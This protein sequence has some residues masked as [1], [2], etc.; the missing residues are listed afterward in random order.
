MHSEPT[1]ARWLRWMVSAGA[2][3]PLVIFQQYLSPFHFG[4]VILFRSLVEV[5]AVLFIMLVWREPDYRPK[6]NPITWTFLALAGV[7]TMTMLTGAAPL[8]SWWGTL[9][10][11]GG[12]FAFWH[13]FAF[14]LIAVSVLR[15]RE[16]WQ[17]LLDLTVAVG[18]VSALYGFLQ[19]THL[20]FIVGA[21]GRARPFGTIG[22]AA[23]F[24]GY[25]LLVG[26][27]AG[28]SL[29]LKSSGPAVRPPFGT[30]ERGGMLIAIGSV[31]T[32]LITLLF[33][34][35]G[36]WVIP[37]GIV[38]YGVY[39]MMAS[40]GSGRLFYGIT[41]A[42]TA[43]AVIMAAVR[44]SLL[45][46]LVSLVVFF[47]LWSALNQSRR[48]KI[49]L[50]SLVGVATLF[51][52]GA[53][54][55]HNTALVKNSPYLLRITDLSIKTFTVQTRL[56]TWT[57]GLQG[58]AESPKTILIGW[59]PENF[60]IPFSRHFDPRHFTGP[61]AETF[62]DRAHNTFVEMLV[63]MGV[64]GLLV[65]G[66]LFFVIFRALKHLIRRS[67]DDRILG[68]GFTAMTVAYLIH[69]SFIFDTSANY[70]VFFT[71]L[72]YIVFVWSQVPVISDQRDRKQKISQ[73]PWSGI[74]IAGVSALSIGALVLVWTMNVAP[75]KANFSLTRGIIASMQGDW[76]TAVAK[77][78]EAI[79]ANVFGRYDFRHRFAQYIVGLTNTTDVNKL[80][81]YTEAVQV[82]IQDMEANSTENPQDLLPY[83]YA[84]R[85]YI[86]L[87]RNDPAGRYTQ[88]SLNYADKA[89]AIS[90]TFVRTYYEVG[91]AYLNLKQYDNAIAAF[92]KAVDLNP[93][94]G[95]SYW[96]LSV[97]EFQRG[98]MKEALRFVNLALQ[99]GYKLNEQDA[100]KLI[101]I[102]INLGD[103][104]NVVM[105]YEH[106]VKVV[107]NN[108]LYWA[109]LAEGYR[110]L[111]RI[112]DAVT[113][114]RKVILF[115]G[116]NQDLRQQAEQFLRALGATP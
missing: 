6:G 62:F 98:D 91:Q 65:Y 7:Y 61:G 28:I 29:L 38:S 22:N 71:L 53:L 56:W 54:A 88:T 89:L 104:P 50:L 99:R 67:G 11:M 83:I 97:A 84:A 82:A 73:K 49:V 74:H 72:G 40:R 33:P 93:N 101:A 26:W 57:S 106:L 35:H 27:L 77:Y 75:A 14:Y 34:G 70:I 23:L 59:G 44:G 24:A 19:K 43:L 2:L 15:T 113:A 110:Q 37:L 115:A 25:Q 60:N 116:D 4:K 10:R 79:D 16:H 66:A 13:Y 87:G 90:P 100:Q 69:N 31:A 58:W 18:L 63:T 48:A 105:A 47:L 41:L 92:Q 8:Q 114:A 9:E 52:F 86:I 94:V 81:N 51:I 32:L 80:P 64:L 12:V 107:P 96:Y 21:D 76:Q 3:V 78:R 95:F 85:L 111:N 45:G 5:M 46:L 68:I 109:G 102:Y 108:P 42:S 17:S 20:S 39:L 1:L 112:S 30:N 103:I 36:L 55:L